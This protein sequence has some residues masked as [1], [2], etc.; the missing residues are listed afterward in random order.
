[1]QIFII[2]DQLGYNA[3]QLVVSFSAFAL[4]FSFALGST[5][6]MFIE[7]IMF[8]FGTKPYEVRRIAP[9]PCWRRLQLIAH[10]AV[11]RRPCRGRRRHLYCGKYSSLH[12]ALHVDRKQVR[13]GSQLY[14]RPEDAREPAPLQE[15]LHLS[16]RRRR[17]G[18]ERGDD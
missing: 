13:D 8:V 6:R 18:R 12:D 7:S 11:G 1:M 16:Q 3:N 15:R 2:A 10:N 9:S 14:P 4:S 17:V 5:I